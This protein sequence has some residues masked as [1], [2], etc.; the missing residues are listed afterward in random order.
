MKWREFLAAH[1][2]MIAAADFFPVEVWTVLGLVRFLM[3]FVIELAT[4]R[5]C[6]AGVHRNPDGEWMDPIGRNLVDHQEGFLRRKRYLNHDGDPSF[7]AEFTHTL[8]GAGVKPIKLRPRSPNL[9]AYAERFGRSIKEE[10]LERMIIFGERGP[11]T[12]IQEYGLHYHFERN[13]RGLGDR[14]IIA[15][16]RSAQSGAVRRKQKLGGLLNY[17]H[18]QAAKGSCEDA[19]PCSRGG[20]SETGVSGLAAGPRRV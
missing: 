12:A 6:I 10:C 14:L 8:G 1:W 13:H 20:Y 15:P 18:R 16:E 9:N 4:R 19:E 5:V 7:T 2:D 17:Y 3:F 11:R